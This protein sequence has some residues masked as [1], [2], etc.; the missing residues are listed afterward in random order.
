MLQLRRKGSHGVKGVG[1]IL[2][3]DWCG[4][5]EKGDEVEGLLPWMPAGASSGSCSFVIIRKKKELKE[6]FEFERI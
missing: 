5:K 4:L 2:G 3:N 1:C 6:L